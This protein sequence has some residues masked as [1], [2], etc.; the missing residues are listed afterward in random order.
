MVYNMC[1]FLGLAFFIA[2]CFN[3]KLDKV[4]LGTGSFKYNGVKI[5]CDPFLYKRYDR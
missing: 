5:V 1:D 4:Q 3:T 2:L